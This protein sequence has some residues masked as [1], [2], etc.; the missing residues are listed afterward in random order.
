LD[1]IGGHLVYYNGE[2]YDEYIARASEENRSI[3]SIIT[4]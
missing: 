3:H 1:S 2:T 4:E